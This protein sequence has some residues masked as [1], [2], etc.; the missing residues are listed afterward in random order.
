MVN[1]VQNKRSIWVDGGLVHDAFYILIMNAYLGPI[2]NYFNPFYLIRLFNR[3]K[4]EKEGDQCQVSQ[5]QANL[6][7][8][9][10][11]FDLSLRYSNII[12]TML[13]AAFYAPVLPIGLVFSISNIF[14]TYW[15]DK[16][17][18]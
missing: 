3:N 15:I 7:F 13:L 14:L 18:I 6:T 9:G 17:K 8:E 1:I 10:T 11:P 2:M 16:V 5:I 12:K 4:I